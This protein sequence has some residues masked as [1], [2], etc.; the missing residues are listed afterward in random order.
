MPGGCRYPLLA[1]LIALAVAGSFASAQSGEPTEGKSRYARMTRPL[2]P[3][4]E[5]RGLD[6]ARQFDP[7][8]LPRLEALKA[9]APA[10]YNLT[11]RHL[12]W[13]D[14]HLEEI[15][16]RGDTLAYRTEVQAFRRMFLLQTDAE[17]IAIRYRRANDEATRAQLRAELKTKLE[18]TFEIWE[19]TKRGEVA[20]M[21]A[22]LEHLRHS[23][24]ERERDKAKIVERRLRRMIEE[25]LTAE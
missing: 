7:E 21:T 6:F 2:A 8:R 11:M 24:E 3:E 17:D 23:L 25:R 4:E 9:Q 22:E 1:F 16:A 20:R 13:L 15:R 14:K 18:Q 12:L 5:G 10:R 19:Q